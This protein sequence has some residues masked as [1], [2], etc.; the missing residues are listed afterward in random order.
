M[1]KIYNLANSK[2]NNAG[3]V[4]SV[5]VEGTN[6]LTG[7]GTVT[8]SGTITLKHGAK[9][10]TGTATTN[11]GRTYI[12][13]ITLDSYGHVASVSTATETVT[14]TGVTDVTANNGLTGTISDRTLTMGISSISTDLLSQGSN[15]LVFSCGGAS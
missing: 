1:N 15:V 6:G 13:N 7:S 5:K 11:T 14:D 2:T 8:S 12:Q 10:T 3:T 9:P 4:T